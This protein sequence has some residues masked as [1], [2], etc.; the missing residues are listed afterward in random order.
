MTLYDVLGVAPDATADQ[1]RRA[2]RKK[3][4]ATHPDRN[5]G[6]PDAAAKHRAVTDAYDVLSDPDRRAAYD[7]DGTTA[8]PEDRSLEELMEAI[9]PVLIG[10]MQA[11]AT[12]PLSAGLAH[13][14]VVAKVRDHFRK[15]ETDARS[16]LHKTRRSVT[17]LDA[18]AARFRVPAGKENFLAGAVKQQADQGRAMITRIEA[19]LALFARALDYLK[20]CSYR[21]DDPLFH[22]GAWRTAGTW[23]VVDDPGELLPPEPPAPKPLPGGPT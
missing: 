2:Y 17:E 1:I 20:D 22:P 9:T 3:A 11:A 7:R 4:A 14:D 15:Q 19:D 21:T 13:T 10:V 18:A 6:D 16:V 12:S 23:A 8:A 5:P